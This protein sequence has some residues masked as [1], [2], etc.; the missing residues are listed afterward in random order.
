MTAVPIP[1]NDPKA[2][3][4]AQREEI[5]AAIVRVLEGG[6]YILGD[7]TSAFERE[8]SAAMG[9]SYGIA[10]GNGTDAI[11]LS[12][13]ALGIGAG[14]FVAT[15]SHT[16]VATIAAIEE[17]GAR[18][19][20]IDIDPNTYTMDPQSLEH[21]LAEA[22]RRG[23]PAAAVVAVHLY[24]Q[25]A[26]L[27]AILPLVARFGAILIE[28]CA[29]SHGATF[30]GKPLG[31]FG[32]VACFSF[33]PTKNLGAFGDGGM[34]TTRDS[35]L[36]AE[37]RAQREY[38]W[39]T[40]RHVSDSI[41]MNSRFDEIQ[42]AILRVKLTRL[43]TN[44]ARRRAIAARY[45]AGLAN[46]ALT[47]PARDPRCTHV[48]HQYVVRLP[49]RDALR[50]ALRQANIMTNVHYPIPVHK[51]PAYD[52]RVAIGPTGLA[53]TEQTAMEIVSLPMYP[54]LAGGQVD[55]VIEVINR[56]LSE[57]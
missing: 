25:A 30:E 42:A 56:V 41:G 33:Y 26:D 17:A 48:F 24:G 11:M 35:W 19:L 38:G 6:S 20:L 27:A 28:D 49:N 7:E 57:G 3:Y 14:E 52:G 12:L 50:H 8:F 44:N 37:L 9:C 31:S 18:P 46:M 16:A 54:Q 5:D 29:Q 43:A 53:Q 32:E 36:A 45:D 21:A 10:V 55:R 15:V 4:F 1:Q 23:R 39:R 51:Q 2:A 22:S 47:K 34:V 13:R 40:R